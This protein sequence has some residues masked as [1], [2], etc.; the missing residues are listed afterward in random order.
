LLQPGD[1]LRW[2]I[3]IDSGQLK[4]IAKKM[5]WNS[6]IVA[7]P[8]SITFSTPAQVQEQPAQVQGQP[9]QVQ[10]QP[11]QPPTQSSAGNPLL[12]N[13]LQ[14]YVFPG[15]LL[16]I[17]DKV[18]VGDQQAVIVSPAVTEIYHVYGS[19]ENVNVI[20]EVKANDLQTAS[21]LSEMIKEQFLVKRRM[22]MEA[23]GLGIFEISS[24][25][26]GEQRD[27]SA[28][29]STYKYNLSISAA[30]DWKAFVPLV[31]R[32]TQIEVDAVETI[33]D[34]PSK[35]VLPIKMKSLGLTQFLNPYE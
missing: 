22:N 12:T 21:E 2:D 5:E 18:V 3:R 17:G 28:T 15:L 23:D 33:P 16:A 35:P 11:A 6:L 25:F 27:Q 19:K 7:D 32:L 1:W 26:I 9:A 31:T 30:A 4:A 24:D 13:G 20:L 29:A 10:G 14:Q 34:F 8:N